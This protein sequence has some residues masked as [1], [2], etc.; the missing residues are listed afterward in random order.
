[1][2]SLETPLIVFD[3]DGTLMDSTGRIV[4]AMQTTARNLELPVP[5]DDEVRSIIGLSL[6]VCYEK[7]FPGVDDHDWITEEYRYQYVEGDRTPSPV[8]EGVV[9]VLTSLKDQGYYL[10]VATGKARYGI[11]RVLNE[12]KLKQFFDRTIA[13]DE[14]QGKPHPEMLHTLLKHFGLVSE[15]AV[16]VGDTSHDLKMAQNAGTHSVGVSYGAH[17]VELLKQHSPMAIID[18]IRELIGKP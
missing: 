7:L 4:S 15:Q 9:D 1:M 3:W 6:G 17:R 10:A 16:M 5:S 8:F 12:S 13:S 18:D 14:A 11:D 2:L